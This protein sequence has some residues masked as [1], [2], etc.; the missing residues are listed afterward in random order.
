MTELDERAERARRASSPTEQV[1]AVKAHVTGVVLRLQSGYLREDKGST[2][3]SVSTLARLRRAQGVAGSAD[4]RSWAL[5]LEGLP[6]ILQASDSGSAVGVKPTRAEQAVHTSLTT[7]A[8]HQQGRRDPQHVRGVG[9]GEATRRLARQRA[10][11]DA[12]GGLDE[13]TV[14]RLHRVSMAQ[15]AE[16]RVDAL[17]ALV[18]LMRGAERTVGLDYGRLAE[19][20]FWLQFPGAAHGVQLSWGRGL[21]RF[22]QHTEVGQDPDQDQSVTTTTTPETS[23]GSA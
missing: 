12:V 13:P 2:S 23:G 1:H 22:N 21:H 18:T 11:E 17:R 10:T 20:L 4:P 19:D 7:Y 3:E 5:V 6:T 16:L 15:T 8:V 9:L 14:Q